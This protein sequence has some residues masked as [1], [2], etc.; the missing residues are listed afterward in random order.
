MYLSFRHPEATRADLLPA[1]A[2]IHANALR[3]LE[4]YDLPEDYRESY[5]SLIYETEREAYFIRWLQ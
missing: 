2:N 3:K 5:L 1:L 4:D